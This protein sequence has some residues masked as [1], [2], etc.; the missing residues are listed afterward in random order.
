LIFSTGVVAPHAIV[1]LQAQVVAADL[2]PDELH[3][4][5]GKIELQLPIRGQRAQH[6]RTQ[7]G[8]GVQRIRHALGAANIVLSIIRA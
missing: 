5:S 3:E 6:S 7:H 4:Q 8:R 2:A 1:E